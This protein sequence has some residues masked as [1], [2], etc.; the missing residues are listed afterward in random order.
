MSPLLLIAMR[1]LWFP[2]EAEEQRLVV[3]D[4]IARL[5]GNLVP[6][7]EEAYRSDVRKRRRERQVFHRRVRALERR[8][9]AAYAH[10]R[11]P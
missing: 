8:M 10:P 5:G 4:P 11:W 7:R 3:Y 6:E 2:A 1:R 9:H